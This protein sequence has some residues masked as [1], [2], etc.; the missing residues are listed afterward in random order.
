MWNTRTSTHTQSKPVRTL[1]WSF[2]FCCDPVMYS[3]T[4][5]RAINCAIS[6]RYK[7]AWQAACFSPSVNQYR[8]RPRQLYF[9]AP[10]FPSGSSYI[11]YQS[12][13]RTITMTF[14]ESIL[15]ALD[16]RCSRGG[17]MFNREAGPFDLSL[18]WPIGQLKFVYY[19]FFRFGQSIQLRLKISH[20]LFQFLFAFYCWLCSKFG[21]FKLKRQ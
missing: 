19:L 21:V 9:E 6:K 2:K 18:L 5:K 1:H 11:L 20:V 7:P 15:N 16:R 12:T 10:Y 3:R 17:L 14:K 13:N 8:L 4:H